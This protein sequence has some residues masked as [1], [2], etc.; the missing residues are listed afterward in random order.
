VYGVNAEL[1]RVYRTPLAGEYTP[2]C[3]GWARCG[4]FNVADE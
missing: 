2:T 4:H 1:R 3:P